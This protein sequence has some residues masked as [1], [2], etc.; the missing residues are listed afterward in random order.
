MNKKILFSF[1]IILI[2]IASFCFAVSESDLL[3]IEDDADLLTEEEETELEH[4]MSPL[5]EYGRIV[6]KSINQNPEYDTETYARNYYYSHYGNENGTILLIDMQY[7]YVYIVSGGYNYT[8]ITPRKAQI[9][10][11]NI[12]KYLTNKE[13]FEGSKLS[14]EQI[15]TLL[16]GGKI[17]EPMRYISSALISLIASAFLVFFFIMRKSAFKKIPNKD[18]VKDCIIA[19][20]A[21]NIIG[22]AV[23]TIK[24]YSPSSSSSGGSSGGGGGRR[25][26]ADFLAVAE[27]TASKNHTF[28]NSFMFYFI[29]GGYILWMRPKGWVKQ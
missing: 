16:E 19:F 2:L 28:F 4:I 13:Y 22:S 11:D 17:Y 27:V 9:I 26:E 25:P 21:A 14:F 6:F 20:S 3:I 15:G 23:G 8:V 12:Y 18:L 29:F 1:I 10:T 24:K 7:R 5:T